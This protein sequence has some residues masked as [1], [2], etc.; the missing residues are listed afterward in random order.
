MQQEYCWIGIWS[1]DKNAR[2]YHSRQTG[3]GLRWKSYPYGDR[4][5]PI[6]LDPNGSQYLYCLCAEG[7]FDD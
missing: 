6:E 7:I 5:N 1:D 3:G 4:P 2:V